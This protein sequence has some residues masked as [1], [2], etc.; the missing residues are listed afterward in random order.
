MQ[1]LQD[2]YG[3]Y[4]KDSNLH[5]HVMGYLRN[6]INEKK[7][8]NLLR[9]IKYS[10]PHSYG[11]P[12]IASI[13][14]AMYKARRNSKSGDDPHRSPQYNTMEDIEPVTDEEYQAGEKM[15]I[16][17]GGIMQKALSNKKLR[18]KCD[19]ILL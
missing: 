13:E 1:K 6:D 10:H 17:T 15:L 12:C 2:Y 14:E 9:Y 16:A 8:D 19:E 11:P 7:L 4:P 5:K 3:G 18:R